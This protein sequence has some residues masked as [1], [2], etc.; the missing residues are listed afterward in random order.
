MNSQKSDS[1]HFK[2]LLHFSNI[3]KVKIRVGKFHWK[4][5]VG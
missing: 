5:K 1:I 3:I 2:L 4:N